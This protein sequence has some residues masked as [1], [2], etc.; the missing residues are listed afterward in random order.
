M[1]FMGEEFIGGA[2]ELDALDAAGKLD[3][4]LTGR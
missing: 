3:S 4:K 2:D 1:I